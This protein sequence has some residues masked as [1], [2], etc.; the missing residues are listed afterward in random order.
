[1]AALKASC[2]VCKEFILS[3]IYILKFTK[4]LI[5]SLLSIF[6]YLMCCTLSTDLLIVT[7]FKF[8]ITI[9]KNNFTAS[10]GL[11]VEK[12][13]FTLITTYIL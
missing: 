1:M 13:L 4:S 6:I 8:F 10:N 11:R 7:V 9:L 5:F 12:Q 3:L 2:T